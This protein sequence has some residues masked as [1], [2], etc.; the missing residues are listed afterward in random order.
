MTTGKIR[1]DQEHDRVG[2]SV[3]AVDVWMAPEMALR[4]A[5]RLQTAAREVG[6]EEPD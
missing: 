1:V 3:G 4:V 5:T 2:L 6:D